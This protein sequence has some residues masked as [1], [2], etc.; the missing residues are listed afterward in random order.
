MFDYKTKKKTHEKNIEMS[1]NKDYITGNLLD[2]AYFS[3][4]YRLIAIDLTKKL[5]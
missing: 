2:Y 3:E 4:Y 5:N 1:K